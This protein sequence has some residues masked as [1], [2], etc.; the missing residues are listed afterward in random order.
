MG[1]VKSSYDR[2]KMFGLKI[3]WMQNFLNSNFFSD[4]KF[5]DPKFFGPKFFLDLNLFGLKIH[6]RMEFGSG[7]GP[8]CFETYNSYHH[9][10]KIRSIFQIDDIH[11]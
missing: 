10:Q 4:S 2:P 5:S 1:Q 3:L 9:V 6:L 8:T 11:V 7:V